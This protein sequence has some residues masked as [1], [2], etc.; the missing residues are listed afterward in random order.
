MTAEVGKPPMSSA[1]SPWA[2]LK[3]PTFRLLW[4]ASVLS[5][6]GTWIHD[7]GAAWLMTDLTP[8]PLMVSLVQTA[9]TLPVLLLA[10]PAGVLA[11]V[12]DRRHVLLFAQLWM[13]VAAALLAT[14]VLTGA[15]TAPVVLLLLFALGIGNALT[16]PAWQAIVPELVEPREVAGAVALN[17]AGINVARA[18]G[19]AIGGVIVAALGPAAAFIANALTF[20]GVSGALASW[21]RTS[22]QSDVPPEPIGMALRTGVRYV[23]HDAGLVAVLVRTLV[24]MSC[25]S[26]LWALLPIVGRRLLGVSALGYGMML[27]AI[28]VGALIATALLSRWRAAIGAERLVRLA[29]VVYAGVLL[30]IATSRNYFLLCAVLVVAGMAWLALLSTFQTAAQL[31][32]PS[33]VRGRALATYLMIFFGGQAAGSLLWGILADR[34]NVPLAFIVAAGGL[35]AGLV[36]APWYALDSTT[37]HDRT[38]SQHWPTHAADLVPASERTTREVT[39]MTT[40]IVD[41]SDV[42]AFVVAMDDLRHARLR[43]GA[44]RWTLQRDLEQST[45]FVEWFSVPSWDEHLRQHDRVTGSDRDIQERVRR[46]HRGDNAPQVRHFVGVVPTDYHGFHGMAPKQQE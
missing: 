42:A 36:L 40:Y 12:F 4:S 17:S 35:L 19:P 5:G 27:G 23:R 6:V 39:V 9:S 18:V 7:V 43:G 22:A 24:F 45:V 32:V 10:L 1:V 21:S 8:S 3:R 26:A 34:T 28:G 33:W 2:P 30:V 29:T 41:E 31:S 13:A 11:D 38:P 20:L 15:A 16:G 46:F 14:A 25:G 44:H 37:R